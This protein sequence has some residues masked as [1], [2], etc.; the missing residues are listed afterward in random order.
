QLG[1]ITVASNAMTYFLGFIIFIFLVSVLNFS[2]GNVS[3]LPLVVFHFIS[4]T[5]NPVAFTVVFIF[6]AFGI[7]SVLYNA[8]QLLIIVFI[9][10]YFYF[11]GLVFIVG[12]GGYSQV[13]D[14]MSQLLLVLVQYQAVGLVEKI[15]EI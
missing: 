15:I 3:I 5:Y 4:F 2:F 1:N 6:V 9:A 13:D 11:S 10:R 8:F 7:F 14:I 12:F